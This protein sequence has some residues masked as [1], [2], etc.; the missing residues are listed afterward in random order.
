[1]NKGI[2]IT[3]FLLC[4]TLVNGM[5]KGTSGSRMYKGKWRSVVHSIGNLDSLI[6]TF[7]EGNTSLEMCKKTFDMLS[8]DQKGSLS[9][10][11]KYSGTHVSFIAP[12]SKETEVEHP[13]RL[14][15]V[16]YDKYFDRLDKQDYALELT[17]TT[18]FLDCT[19]SLYLLKKNGSGYKISYL[20]GEKKI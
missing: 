2:C 8:E 10:C 3:V 13:I 1:M 5:D 4:F 11:I 18:S 20:L 15:F 14:S 9:T 16:I 17:V 12:N 7:I 6:C 19:R